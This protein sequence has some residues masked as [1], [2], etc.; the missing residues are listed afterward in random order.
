MF[1]QTNYNATA[2]YGR[3][4]PNLAMLTSRKFGVHKQVTL[5][6]ARTLQ[7]AEYHIRT[8]QGLSEMRYIHSDCSPIYGTGQGSGNLPMIWCFISSLLYKCYDN[9][10]YPA[11]YSNPD[12]TKPL[13]WSLIG[14][15]D[16]SNGQVNMFQDQDSITN[17]SMLNYKFR[18]SG[19][20]SCLNDSFRTIQVHE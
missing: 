7:Q 16:N 17:A 3:I 20:F 1:L 13:S 2:C 6:Y 15:V 4:I 8:E 14:F 11:T 12:R 10:S 18:H 19:P 9:K 5:S